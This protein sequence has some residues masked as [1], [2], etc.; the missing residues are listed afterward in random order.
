[1]TGVLIRRKNRDTGTGAPCED[2]DTYREKR[3][4]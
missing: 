2:I 4:V 3:A 1:M